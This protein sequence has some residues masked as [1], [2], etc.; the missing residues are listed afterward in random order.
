MTMMVIEH[1]KASELPPQW[2][3]H[4]QAKPDETFTVRVETEGA[5]V[6]PSASSLPGDEQAMPAF[7]IWHDHP[8][9]QDVQAYLCKLRATR[10]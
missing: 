1:V 9:S 2:A 4:L 10:Y 8:E 6:A 5:R 7:G 3:E